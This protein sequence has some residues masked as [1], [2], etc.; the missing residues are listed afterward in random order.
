[1]TESFCANITKKDINH[2]KVVYYGTERNDT[3]CNIG[4]G[5]N[6]SSMD[7]HRCNCFHHILFES[8]NGQSSKLSNSNSGVW[9]SKIPNYP[10]QVL[11]APRQPEKGSS[12]DAFPLLALPRQ[13]RHPKLQV[14]SH[15]LN[16]FWIQFVKTSKI[17]LKPETLQ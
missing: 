4:I 17:I 1:M 15:F 14:K 13:L 12:A 8:E 7:H 6:T 11:R 2:T 16:Q 9:K 5:L 3:V 10:I